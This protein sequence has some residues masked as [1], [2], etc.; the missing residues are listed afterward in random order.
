MIS[1]FGPC[2][3]L[4]QLDEGRELRVAL[5]ELCNVTTSIHED[6]GIIAHVGGLVV[7]LG[8]TFLPVGHDSF[9]ELVLSRVEDEYG[10]P[11][12]AIVA[13]SLKDKEFVLV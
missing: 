13:D 3:L 11:T 10:L 12:I 9:L 1:P 6:D 8:S 5:F 4:S 2:A 7:L